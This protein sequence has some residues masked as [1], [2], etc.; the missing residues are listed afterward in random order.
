ME[1]GK[2]SSLN[3]LQTGTGRQIY[4]SVISCMMDKRFSSSVPDLNG[5]FAF[6][7]QPLQAF[8]VATL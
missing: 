5:D 7:H 4:L 2:G 3:L 6:L 1:M 8:Q